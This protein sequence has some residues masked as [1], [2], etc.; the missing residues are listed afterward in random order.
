MNSVDEIMAELKIF[1]KNLTYGMKEFKQP[2][3]NKRV[4]EMV[5]DQITILEKV[6]ERELD[7]YQIKELQDKL[8]KYVN[9]YQ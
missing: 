8:E 1:H 3:S 6:L 9:N 4:I 7:S 5:Q 2:A